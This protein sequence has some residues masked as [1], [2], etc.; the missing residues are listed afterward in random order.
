MQYLHLYIASNLGLFIMKYYGFYD[1]G[2]VK[3]IHYDVIGLAQTF[4]LHIQYL[5]LLAIYLINFLFSARC[6]YTT[7]E[8]LQI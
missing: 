1:K 7:Y 8:S 3:N 2:I 5:H 6:T 4:G